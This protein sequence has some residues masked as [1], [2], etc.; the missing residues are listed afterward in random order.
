MSDWFATKVVA[1]AS[2]CAGIR[3]LVMKTKPILGFGLALALLPGSTFGLG[4]RAPEQDAAAAARANAVVATADNASAL[5]Y[6]PAGISFL[7]GVN[8]RSGFYGI[9]LKDQYRNSAG[10][11]YDTRDAIGILPETYATLPIKGTPLTV[12]LGIYS[13]YGLSVE[14]PNGVPSSYVGQRGSMLYATFN[15]VLAWKICDTLSLGAGPTINYSRAMLARNLPPPAPAG[16]FKFQGDGISLGASAGLLWKPHEKHSF[17]VSYRS[18]TTTDFH[19]YSVVSLA[20]ALRPAAEA[21]F[22]F[23]QNVIV[24]YSFRP[25]PKWNLEFDL[26][27]T[28]WDSQSGVVL[29]PAAA[30][31]LGPWHSSFMFEWGVTRYLGQG[32]QISAGYAYSQNSIPDSSFNPTVAD[33]DRH[34]FSAGFGHKGKKLSWDVGYQFVYGPERNV[35]ASLPPVNGQYSF[36]SHALIAS[37]G[38]SF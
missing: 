29:R 12:G 33:C 27:W 1:A 16:E 31:A 21:R 6:N 32:W 30:Q 19:G 3:V 7:E 18:P 22:Q 20:P 25:T 4:I 9:Y 10:M 23:P 24:G 28:D 38:F 2:R 37:V 36:F 34:V 8:L 14:W 26:D 17:G 35:T 11:H 13:P 5:Y 15:P